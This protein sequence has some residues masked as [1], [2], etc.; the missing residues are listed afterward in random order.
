MKKFTVLSSVLASALMMTMMSCSSSD[1]LN[2]GGADANNKSYLAIRIN[3]VGSVAGSRAAT[4]YS[5]GTTDENHI[6]SVRFYFFNSDGTPYILKNNGQS[7]GKNWLEKTETD[8]LNTGDKQNPNVSMISNPL[9]VIEGNTGASPAVMIAVINPKS[10]DGDKLGDGAKT[11]DEVKRTSIFS[12]FYTTDN[13]N[14]VMSNSTFVANGVE[15]CASV[16]TGHVATDAVAATGNPVDLYVERVVAKVQPTI[17]ATY[18][19]ADGR[20]W[21]KINGQDAMK[22]GVYGAN[23]IYAVVDGWGVADEN[24]KAELVKQVDTKWNDEYLGIS[25][26]TSPDYNRCFWTSSVAFAAGTGAEGNVPVNHSYKDFAA[27]KLTDC[28]YTLPN[29]PTSVVSDPYASTLTK[30][31]LATHLVYKDGADYKPA[32]ICQ[33]RGQEYLHIEDVKT[34]VANNFAD[35]Y[36]MKGET[37]TKLQPSDIEFTTKDGIKDYQ[38]VATLR[39][40]AADETLQKKT[41]T[42][43]EASSYQ[44]VDKETL[45]NLMNGN[46]AQIRKDGMAYYYVPIRHLGTDPKKL[47][48]YGIV[49]NHVYSINIQNMY[50]FGTPV[51]DPTKVIDPTIPSNDATYLAARINVLSWRVVKYNADLDK[52]K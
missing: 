5:D 20:K 22:V 38:V 43:E 52:T 23:D 39:S 19:T 37:R 51:F 13:K 14:F 2:G 45:Q 30:M 4:D 7:T 44:N 31:V 42:T 9:L 27:R 41:G 35:Y 21:E 32:E 24:G 15:K 47:G 40:L 49:R 8:G 1:D 48:Y 11:L 18:A 26:W 50:G 28:A 46:P 6:E 17:D 16:V 3:N 29:A 34:E 25:V 12:Q 36:I 33:Y 10:L